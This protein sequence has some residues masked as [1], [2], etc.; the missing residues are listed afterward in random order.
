MHARYL[1]VI[2]FSSWKRVWPLI[3]AM[4]VYFMKKSWEHEASVHVLNQ[5]N[6]QNLNL[7]LRHESNHWWTKLGIVWYYNWYY[8]LLNIDFIELSFEQVIPRFHFTSR[9][10]NCKQNETLYITD[11]QWRHIFIFQICSKVSCVLSCQLFKSQKYFGP[12]LQ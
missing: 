7:F 11:K 8:H 12:F 9:A 10:L 4:P 2:I 1:K 5:T 6:Y 3:W